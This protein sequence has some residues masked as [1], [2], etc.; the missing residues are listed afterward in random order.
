MPATHDELNKIW[1]LIK[2]SRTAMLAS[3]DNGRIRSRPMGTCQDNFDDGCVWFF[4]RDSSPKVD[5]VQHEHQVNVS[6]A[7]DSS[8]SY[9]SLSGSAQLVRDRAAIEAHWND[10]VKVWFPDGIDDPALAMLKITVDQAEYWD[11]SSSKMVLAFQYL[12]ARATGGTPDM[13]ETK[14]VDLR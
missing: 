1:K 13:G 3:E 2:D 12:K 7:S 6:Y 8:N 4:T 5:Q 11:S 10:M 9:V 14:K